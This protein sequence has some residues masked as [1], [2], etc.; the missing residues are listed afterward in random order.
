MLIDELKELLKRQEG[1]GSEDQVSEMFV[2]GKTG[3][4]PLR[5]TGLKLMKNASF[6]MG[7]SSS[8]DEIIIMSVGKDLIKY[9]THPFKK[10]LRIDKQSGLHLIKTGVKTWLKSGYVKRFPKRARSYRDWLQG[11][12]PYIIEPENYEM[13]KVLIRSDS[14]DDDIY[15]IG[16]QY[17]V[18]GKWDERENS[19]EVELLRG[20]LRS[21]LKE[22]PHFDVKVMR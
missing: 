1:G 19:V 16:K 4:E 8:P 17:G 22:Y 5:T 9:R 15:G 3:L 2:I 14:R 6:H 7:A 21:M 18:V 11:G 20:A 13:V 10:E 12:T